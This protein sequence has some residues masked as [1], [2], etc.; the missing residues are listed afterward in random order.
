LATRRNFV[1]I[2]E[3]PLKKK[4]DGDAEIFSEFISNLNRRQNTT[5]LYKYE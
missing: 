4:G 5:E 1:Q 3:K 2:S